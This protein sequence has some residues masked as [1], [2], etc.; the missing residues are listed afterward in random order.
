MAWAKKAAGAGVCILA[1]AVCIWLICVR[2]KGEEQKFSKEI[3]AM[4]TLVSMTFY[5]SDDFEQVSEEIKQLDQKF[6]A[7][8]QQGEVYRLNESGGGEMDEDVKEIIEEFLSLYD[9]YGRVSPIM[10]SI[11]KL[12]DVTGDDPQVPNRQEI[13]EELGKTD[14]NNI[15][16]KGSSLNLKNEAQLD[17]GAVG[18]GYALDKVRE[19]LQSGGVTCSVISFGSSTLLYGKKPDKSDFKVSVKD[20][21]NDGEIMLNFTCGEGFV[22]TSG[23]YERYF[24]ADGKKYIHIFDEQTGEPVQTDLVS[25]T[26]MC[27]NGMLSDF[28][29]TRIFMGGTQEI[30]SWLEM[31]EI[32]VI[33]CDNKGNVYCSEN[34]KES[35]Q[36]QSDKYNLL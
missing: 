20:P 35:I 36:M 8:N 27:K 16:A 5:G 21:E 7:Y 14:I 30:E 31:E 26:V 29:S 13:L 32:S 22:S 1:A 24:E 15:E 33:A 11:V 3:F 2:S 17:F 6:D 34:I 28:L 25:A 4:D 23:G 18:K 9:E 10:G 12:W 19:I